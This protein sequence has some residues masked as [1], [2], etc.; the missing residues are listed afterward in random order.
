M[1]AV[2]C[3]DHHK[4]FN[5]VLIEGETYGFLGVR[6]A[7]TY[8][9]PIRSIYRPCEEYVVVLLPD[10][11]INTPQR[12]IWI[13]ECP[14]ALREF[15][16]VYRQPVDTLA[17]KK[18]IIIHMNDPHLQYHIWEWSRAAFHFKTLAALHVKISRIFYTQISLAFLCKQ[19]RTQRKQIRETA[20]DLALAI[21]DK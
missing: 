5:N 13:L 3:G 9:D 10:T 20:R 19:I 15:E 11:V 7:P 4:L 21:M 1:E 2:A 18:L 17:R 8:V 14:R 12:P 6:F 16:D